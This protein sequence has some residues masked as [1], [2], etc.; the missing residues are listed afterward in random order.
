M[1][2][3]KYLLLSSYLNLYY[4]STKLNKK[5]RPNKHIHDIH[6][7]TTDKKQA[8]SQLPK[9]SHTLNASFTIKFALFL[10][11]RSFFT[12]KLSIFASAKNKIIIK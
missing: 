5:A 6:H 11:I 3:C 4:P 2:Y 8:D 7:D 1:P 12:L 10:Q 9:P